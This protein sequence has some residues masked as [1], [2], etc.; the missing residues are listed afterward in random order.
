MITGMKRIDEGQTRNVREFKTDVNLE[1]MV[2]QNGFP[3]SKALRFQ[4][5]SRLE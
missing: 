4:I 3:G 1:R 5:N 2:G